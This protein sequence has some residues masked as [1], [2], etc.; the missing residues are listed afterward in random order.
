MPILAASAAAWSDED[1]VAANRER[2]AERL[3]LAQRILGNR[4]GAVVPQGGFFLW[5]EVGNGEEAA[6][7]LWREAGLR[8]LPGAYMGREV[9][10][11]NPLSNPG[12]KFIRVALVH[13]LSTIKTAL[14]R[15]SEILDQP[16]KEA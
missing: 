4:F 11:G 13:E 7:R 5:L 8:V 6:L 1:H 12:F 2:Y 15:M 3:H 16:S 9:E 14:D 10:P